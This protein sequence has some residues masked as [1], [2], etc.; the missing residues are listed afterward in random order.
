MAFF[1]IVVDVTDDSN[2]RTLAFVVPQV[3]SDFSLINQ[4]LASIDQVEALTGLDF[5]EMLEDIQE[6]AIEA[7][8]PAHIW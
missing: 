7:E 8:K 1:K 5:L 2:I 3:A 6:D 4:Y